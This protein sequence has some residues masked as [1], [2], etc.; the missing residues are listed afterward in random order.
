MY[1]YL[2][3]AKERHLKLSKSL[4]EMNHLQDFNHR[5][6]DTADKIQLAHV[7]DI[8]VLHYL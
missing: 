6:Y 1:L 3:I 2:I 5:R 8:F 7:S 4:I